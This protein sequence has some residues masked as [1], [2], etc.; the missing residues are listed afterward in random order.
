M[1]EICVKQ[2]HFNKVLGYGSWGIITVTL[3][4]LLVIH[5]VELDSGHS[6]DRT[7]DGKSVY[8]NY[9]CYETILTHDDYCMPEKYFITFYGFSIMNA[10]NFIVIGLWIYYKQDKFRFT[11]C[12]E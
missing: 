4:S 7:F 12:K 5:L 6:L 10:I 8:R 3:I 1:K 2:S 9:Y 11:W